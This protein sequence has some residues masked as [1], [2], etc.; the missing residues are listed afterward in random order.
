MNEED[1]DRLISEVKELR[2]LVWDEEPLH[3]LAEK[4]LTIIPKGSSTLAVMSTMACVVANIA[5]QSSD[6][7]RASAMLLANAIIL[8]STMYIA[9][10]TDKESGNVH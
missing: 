2:D 3:D 4:I 5:V 6:G 9:E 1:R 7:K 8:C 10:H